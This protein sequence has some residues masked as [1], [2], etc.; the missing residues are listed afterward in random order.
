MSAV[1]YLVKDIGGMLQE[2]E[3][4]GGGIPPR[5]PAGMYGHSEGE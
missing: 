4:L 2:S 3:A 5:F 1:P